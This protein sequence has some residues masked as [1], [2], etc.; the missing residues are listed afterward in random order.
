MKRNVDRV[1]LRSDKQSLKEKYR[2]LR[3]QNVQTVAR[4]AQH[5]RK[6]ALSARQLLS[7][8]VAQSAAGSADEDS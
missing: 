3:S 5:D 1:E 6:L 7:V 2:S 8:T 4:I